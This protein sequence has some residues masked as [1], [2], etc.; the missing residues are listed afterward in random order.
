MKFLC[1]GIIGSDIWGTLELGECIFAY[2]IDVNLWESKVQ[3]KVSKMMAL[4]NDDCLLIP[5]SC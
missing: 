5:R 3:A 2:G 1:D 4:S